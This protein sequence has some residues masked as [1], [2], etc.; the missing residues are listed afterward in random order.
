MNDSAKSAAELV[1]NN[2]ILLRALNISRVELTVNEHR[3]LMKLLSYL[4][5]NIDYTKAM[6]HTEIRALNEIK[7][8]LGEHL[9]MVNSKYI[10]NPETKIR[11]LGIIGAVKVVSSLVFDKIDESDISAEDVIQPEDMAP[12][13]IRDAMK[14]VELIFAAADKNYE[15]LSMFFD[16]MSVEFKSN[17]RS[18]RIISQIFINWFAEKVF[19]LLNEL[20]LTKVDMEKLSEFTFENRFENIDDSYE[21]PELTVP[22]GTML[23]SGMN[24]IIVIPSL[25]KLTY[26]AL[27]FRSGGEA[28]VQTVSGLC[29][30]PITLPEKFGTSDDEL[31]D[32]AQKA[33]LQLDLYFHCCNWIRELISGKHDDS[34]LYI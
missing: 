14:L 16:E 11:R 15:M 33:K 34:F 20:I 22:L 10:N 18:L 4:V 8:T 25:F 24:E 21:N 28:A 3:S 5:Y 31:F 12:G 7:D 9:N 17:S 19:D 27:I 6:R 2:K 1:Y 30:M 26:L 23:F 29:A 13:P 32:D